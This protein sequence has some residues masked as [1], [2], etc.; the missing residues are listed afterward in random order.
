MAVRFRFSQSF[1]SRL[2]RPSHANVRSTTHRFGKTTTVNDEKTRVC[3]V[4]EG[5]FDFL[6]YTFGR[7]Y[8]ARTGQAYLG[9][10]PSKKSIKRMVEN[11]HALTTRSWT[12]Q[13]V[14]RS[15]G[16]HQRQCRDT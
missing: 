15:T 16:R 8:S 3:K 2:H 13:P 12:W 4:P 1:A 6:G 11:V 14:S 10:R 5:Q 9:Y 7:M